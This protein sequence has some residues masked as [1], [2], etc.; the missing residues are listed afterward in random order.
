MSKITANIRF[1]LSDNEQ[2]SEGIDDL[3]QISEYTFAEWTEFPSRKF[4]TV[5]EYFLY[6]E[7]QYVID[8]IYT[9]LDL[10]PNPDIPGD[11][12]ENEP[13]LT[14]NYYVSKV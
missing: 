13:V 2:L 1:M 4:L 14:V 10:I 6:Q 11:I 12:I 8:T 5:G 9:N 3:S 7:E